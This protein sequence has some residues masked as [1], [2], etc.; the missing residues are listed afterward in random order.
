MFPHHDHVESLPLNHKH[1]CPLKFPKGVACSRKQIV[2][3][4]FASLHPHPHTSAHTNNYQMEEGR[5]LEILLHLAARSK[6][7]PLEHTIDSACHQIPTILKFSQIKILYV[8]VCVRLS[9][10]NE[11]RTRGRRQAR[12]W[13]GWCEI[14]VRFL[15][16]SDSM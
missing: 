10:E 5:G 8:C 11:R 4:R 12:Q 16:S 1:T 7:P 13:F 3:L 14:V 15:S 9:F 2:Q 6:T